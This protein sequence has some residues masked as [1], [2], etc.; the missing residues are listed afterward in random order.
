[1]FTPVVVKVVS[2]H[3]NQWRICTFIFPSALFAMSSLSW[4]LIWRP[5]PLTLHMGYCA[6]HIFSVVAGDSR[7]EAD[8]ARPFWN[9]AEHPAQ[10]T[11]PSGNLG[12][13]WTH[14]PPMDCSCSSSMPLCFL[15]YVPHNLPFSAICALTRYC[16]LTFSSEGYFG[17]KWSL[18]CLTE[19]FFFQ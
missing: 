13:Q 14:L 11:P 3:L 7:N 15:R 4:A 9:L 16:Q 19:L 10:L 12:S 1:M 5:N 8:T 2:S 17:I 18:Y 6:S